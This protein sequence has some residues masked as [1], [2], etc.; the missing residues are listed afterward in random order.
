MI[1]V[2]IVF[3]ND[4]QYTHTHNTCLTHKTFYAAVA[5]AIQQQKPYKI[6]ER[7]KCIL[8]TIHV[9]KYISNIYTS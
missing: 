3:I 5:A 7:E 8:Y 2:S 4:V 9:Y 6:K 1:L